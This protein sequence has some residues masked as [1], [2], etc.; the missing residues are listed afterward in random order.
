M[1]ALLGFA[2]GTLFTWGPLLYVMGR[3]S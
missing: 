2:L 3:K 1:P